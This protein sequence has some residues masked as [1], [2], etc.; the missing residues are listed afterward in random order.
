MAEV[1]PIQSWRSPYRLNMKK[2]NL[3]RFVQSLV[4]FPVMSFPFVFTPLHNPEIYG[5]SQNVLAQ[6]VNIETETTPE[7]L[8]LNPEAID[9]Q[10]ALQQIKDQKVAAIDRYFRERDMPLEGMGM[11]MVLEAEKNG[12]DWRLLPAIAIQ[13]ST[14]GKNMFAPN[15]PF[16]WGKK[17][18]FDSFDQAIETV[19]RNLGGNNPN[20]DHHYAGKTTEEILKTYNPPSVVHNYAKQVM[21]IMKDIG[22]ED[23]TSASLISANT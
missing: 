20:T 21:N 3:I 23:I 10:V 4:I 1:F 13:E 6:K 11:K 14:A 12:L 22:E 15:N 16:G 17:I 7:T 2:N 8:A 19:A 18:K 5:I 9:M